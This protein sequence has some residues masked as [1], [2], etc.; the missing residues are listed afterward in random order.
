M[1]NEQIVFVTK[2]F[3]EDSPKDLETVADGMKRKMM[4][5]YERMMFFLQQ[6]I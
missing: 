5:Y 3:I 4:C 6:P 1:A 2:P